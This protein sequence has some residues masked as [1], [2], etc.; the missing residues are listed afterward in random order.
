MSKFKG[1]PGPWL[2]SDKTVY[3]LN[4]DG[5]NRFSALVQD[6]H[7]DDQELRANAIL[8]AA[9]PDI[10]DA[11]QYALETL[12]DCDMDLFHNVIEV[13]DAAIAKALGEGQP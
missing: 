4:E 10:L 12:K 2:L 8:I 13:G 3:A 9:A 7:T 5:Y 6:A 1:T 11:L